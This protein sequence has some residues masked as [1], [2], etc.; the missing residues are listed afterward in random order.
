MKQYMNKFLT[1]AA[2]MMLTSF[3]AR[4]EQNVKTVIKPSAAAGMVTYAIANGVCTLTVTPASGYYMT[5]EYL[6]AVTTLHGGSVQT[7]RRRIDIDPGTAVAITAT[8]ASADPSKATTYTFSMP[9]NPDFDVEVT[10]NFQ[11]LIPITPSVKLEGWAYG[12]DPKTPVVEG[13]PGNGAVTFT[14]KAEGATEFTESVPQNAGTHTVKASVAAANKYA[15][16]EATNTF[17]IS[18]AQLPNFKVSIESWT[19]GE[20]PKT[21][22]VEGN[23]GNGAVTFTYSERDKGAFSATVPANADNYDVKA[24]VAETANYLG[25]EDIGYFTIEQAESDISFDADLC[26]TPINMIPKWPVLKN[27]KG[28]KVTYSSTNTTV[29]TVDQDGKVNIVGIGETYISAEVDDPNYEYVRVQYKLTVKAATYDLKVNG[30]VVTESNRDDLFNDNSVKFDGEVRLWL[31]DAHIQ[32]IESGLDKLEIYLKGENEIHGGNQ[33][34]IQDLTNG[35]QELIFMTSSKDLGS[36][37]LGST[38]QIIY[39]FSKID[40][41]PPLADL[42]ND[43]KALNQEGRQ[44]AKIGVPLPLFV[45]SRNTSATVD[46]GTNPGDVGTSTLINITIGNVLYTMNDTQTAGANDDGFYDGMIVLNSVM[47]T[48][49]NVPDPNSLIPGSEDYAKAFKGLTFLL[50]PGT[51]VITLTATTA[52]GHALRVKVGDQVTI[53]ETHGKL[54]TVEVPYVVPEPT[55]V[56]IY[57][58]LAPGQNAPDNNHRIGPKATVSTGITG[59]SVSA[60]NVDTPPGSQPDYRCLSM[61]D[62]MMPEGGVGHIIVENELVTDL[63]GDSFGDVFNDNNPSGR[64]YGNYDITYIDLRGTSITGKKFSRDEAPFNELPVSTFIYLPAGNIVSGP[65]MVVGSVCDSL[66]L[67]SE[68][69]TFECAAGGFAATNARFER[70]FA[71]NK[72]LPIYLPFDVKDPDEYGTFYEFGGVTNGVVQMIKTKTVTADTPFYLKAKKGG[73]NVIE[74]STVLIQPMAGAEDQELLGTY[75]PLVLYDDTYVYDN[76]LKKFR[77]AALDMVAPFEAYLTIGRSEETLRTQWEGE[78]SPSA[79][80]AVRNDNAETNQWYTLD[81][82]MLQQQP[83]QKGVYLKNGKKHIVK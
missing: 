19:Y 27:L 43:G 24:V 7:P 69:Y 29:A 67:G 36:L 78:E 25:A 52:E 47:A 13:N 23:L 59:L 30:V 1:I 45:N 81:G 42:N 46:Y 35:K 10:A 66:L 11:T 4:A 50:P 76:S 6:S 39:G 51:G 34:A 74:E 65:N 49:D 16:G 70:S 72:K 12:E 75:T 80:D 58:V 26:E 68:D 3:G 57:H 48:D 2:L 55:I 37:D 79:V 77:Q 82:R 38:K 63:N 5:A 83:T 33:Y 56:Q 21:P 31:M 40:L 61:S 54:L 60:G 15:A 9:E 20:E 73:V 18:K 44:S 17:N 62:I 22:T 32:S 41:Y 71:D 53:I 28:V 14:Y 64:A 8:D